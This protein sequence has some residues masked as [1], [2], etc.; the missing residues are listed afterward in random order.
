M[1]LG[2]LLRQRMKQMGFTPETL[3]A[4]SM[5]DTQLIQDMLEDRVAAGDV[6]TFYFAVLGHVLMCEQDFFQD[7]SVRQKDLVYV[8]GSRSV[9]EN[10]AIAKI[11]SIARDIAFLERLNKE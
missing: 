4:E 9:Q 2:K 8:H 1:T 10:K 5:L 7:E 3:A 11:Q 6:E